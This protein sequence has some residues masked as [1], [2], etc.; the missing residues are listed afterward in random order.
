MA[1]DP[2]GVTRII[3]EVFFKYERLHADQFYILGER[4]ESCEG[5]RLPAWQRRTGKSRS[6]VSHR[7]TEP[8]GLKPHKEKS[9][10]RSLYRWILSTIWE[11][12]DTN[13]HANSFRKQSWGNISCPIVRGK[14]KMR[15][16]QRFYKKKKKGPY[17]SKS[18]MNTNKILDRI[19][20]LEA[21]H[22]RE[23][24]TLR[25]GKVYRRC[26]VFDVWKFVNKFI[27]LAESREKKHDHLNRCIK[28]LWRNS[29]PIHHKL[30][31]DENVLKLTEAPEE[32]L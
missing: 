7:E 18:L 17:R 9:R 20:S 30:R 32:S 1:T 2:T 19:F 8:P 29:T 25:S 27:V 4:D 28:S 31:M 22:C 5:R 3:R 16:K 26:S 6:F 10:P 11:R 23:R 15:I 24:L 21:K 12:T 13:R 14:L